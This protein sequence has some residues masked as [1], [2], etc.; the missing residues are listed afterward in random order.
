MNISSSVDEILQRKITMED[1][2]DSVEE[3]SEQELLDVISI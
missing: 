1:T 2:D 3:V